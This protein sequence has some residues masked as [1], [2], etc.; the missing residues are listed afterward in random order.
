[1]SDWLKVTEAAGMK[2]EPGAD[3]EA[4]RLEQIAQAAETY[5]SVSATID[6]LQR[7]LEDLKAQLLA[8]F[9]EA[10]EEQHRTFGKYTVTVKR[11]ERWTWDSDAVEAMVAGGTLPDFVK[12]TFTVDKRKFV[13]QDSVVRDAYLPAL[14]RKP[15]PATLNV[16]TDTE[17]TE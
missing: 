6:T 2:A 17:P 5:L 8:E 4:K 9:D 3:A 16:T 10:A 12:K 13:K 1:M 11:A 15:G 14:T 7:T